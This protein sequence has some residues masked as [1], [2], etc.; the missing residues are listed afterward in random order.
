MDK[1]SLLSRETLTAIIR[2]KMSIRINQSAVDRLD[3]AV[4]ELMGVG[5]TDSRA[6]DLLHRLGP[7]SAG[8][9]GQEAGL[10]SGA[11]TALIDR[12][13]RAGYVHRKPDPDDRRRVLVEVTGKTEEIIALIFD[14]Y[15]EIGRDLMTQFTREDMAKIT[16]F[17]LISA[18]MSEALA[19][20]LVGVLAEKGRHE[21]PEPSVLAERFVERFHRD[22]EEIDHNL[23]D[24]VAEAEAKLLPPETQE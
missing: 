9:L 12:L 6:L 24:A 23:P 10:T 7:M 11:V 3:E 22:M 2:L 20:R 15:A 19:D 13:E 16:R 8:A 17:N 18:Q 14:R 1:V 5:R 4:A 21:K